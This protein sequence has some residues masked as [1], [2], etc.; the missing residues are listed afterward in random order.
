MKSIILQNVEKMKEKIKNNVQEFIKE[1][2]E[3][4]PVVEVSIKENFA[5]L[6]NGRKWRIREPE[7]EV[8]VLL[9][10]NE[11]TSEVL[12]C[13]FVGQKDKNGTDVREGDIVKVGGLVE[14]VKYIDGILCCYSPEIYGE[15]N[16]I[17]IDDDN[18]QGAIVMDSK[19]FEPY[20][21]IGNINNKTDENKIL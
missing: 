13:R 20:E 8:R 12:N 18:C 15:I 16:S 21:I 7:V 19:Y 9:D 5:E 14:V 17:D 4:I 6:S 10:V 3:F 2:V 1:N 11:D